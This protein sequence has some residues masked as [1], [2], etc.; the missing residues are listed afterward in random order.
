V[1]E[2]PRS[3]QHRI[4]AVAERLDQELVDERGHP[5]PPELVDEVVAEHAARLEEAPVQEFVPLLVEKESRDDLRQRGMRRDWAAEEETQ[6]VD[7]D[8]G[9]E[10][11]RR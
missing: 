4:Q 8:D 2:Q 11:N 3:D 6:D 9:R 7:V 10:V 5:V 1:S